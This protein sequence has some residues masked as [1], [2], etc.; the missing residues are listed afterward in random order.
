MASVNT[1][2]CV[3]GAINTNMG[4]CSFDPKNFV[5]A[6]L[7]PAGYVIPATAFASAGA[8][9][10]QLQNDM[11]N[12]NKAL[13]IYPIGNFFGFKDGSEKPVEEKFDYGPVQTV[14]DGISDWQFRFR[15]GALN[16]SNA[17]RS[18]NGSAWSFM[19]IDSKNQLVGTQAVDSLGNNTIGSINPIE[20]Y[21]DPFIPNDGKK[22][23]EYWSKFRFLAKY[24]NDLVSY[25]TNAAFDFVATI[26]GLITVNL[27]GV[28]TSTAG[29]YKI[30]PTTF[31]GGVGLGSIYGTVLNS[32]ALWTAVN[33]TTGATIPITGV[34]LDA[35]GISFDLALNTTSP[36]YPAVSGKITFNL[37]GPTELAAANVLNYESSG[38]V[39]VT[40]TT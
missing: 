34:V 31:P 11:R 7:C 30:T 21:Q 37:V 25:V 16:L 33:T 2:S 6:F 15:L 40:R 20:F 26:V 35:D 12:D 13:R 22:T 32:S 28:E 23:S 14:R 36:P 3:S 38:G 10:T 39:Q 8:L 9:Q 1:V 27:T 18:Y 17:L 29:T 19:F 4:S 5:G 24:V